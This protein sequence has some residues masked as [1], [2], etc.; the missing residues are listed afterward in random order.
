M[1]A[2]SPL[3]DQAL[4][5]FRHG[6]YPQAI[7]LLQQV[8]AMQPTQLDSRLHLTKACLD[9][10]HIQA[11][12]PLTEIEPDTLGEEPLHYLQM[13]ESHLDVLAKTHAASP[14]VQNL[15]AMVHLIHA[16]YTDALRCLKKAQAK[17]PLNP[18]LMYNA[19]YALMGMKRYGEAS[20]QFKRLTALHS[21]HGMG[22]QMLGE[23]TRLAGKSEAALSAYR[24]AI[25]QLPGWFQ[26]HGALGCALR[27]LGRYDEAM[28]AMGKGL[29]AQPDNRDLNFTL[30]NCALSI[31]AWATGWRH[32][33]CR[34]SSARRVPFPEEYV[35]PLQPGQPVR[36][37]YD[38]GLGDELFFLRFV[39]ALV[40]KGMTIH[41]TTQRKLFPL[42]Q[43]HPDIAELKVAGGGEPEPY[44]VLVGDLPY[45]AGMR[46][47][48][49]IPPSLTLRL[50]HERVR[51]LRGALAAFGPPPYLGITWQGGKIKETVRKGSWQLLHKEIAPATLGKIARDWPGTVVVLQRAPKP[52]DVASFSKALGRTWLDWSGL[53]DDLQDA[54]AGLSLLDDYVG[55]SNTNMHLLAGIG[56][57]A[58]VL[59][60]HP[61]EWRWMAAGEESP[62]FPGFK[63]YRQSQDNTWNEALARLKEDLSGYQHTRETLQ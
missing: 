30:A 50:D 46:S 59:V 42:L 18:D 63:I 2:Q 23:A 58:R 24:R 53:N 14:R 45:L 35:I 27:D 47:T 32:Y 55:V 6:A 51:S 22:W 40:A 49:D 36:V 9:W 3:L 54:L 7:S 57:I 37:H 56:K 43:G 34:I 13:A 15:L 62:W 60:P 29:S 33:A 52:E 25:T 16:R 61:A 41:Y 5:L 26:P 1:P 8:V 28:A 21:E 11:Q 4:Q 20:A 48:T 10:V 31:E 38:Q 44:D 39:P 19:G 12:T 17:D